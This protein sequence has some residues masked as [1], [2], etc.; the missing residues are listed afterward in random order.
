[1]YIYI[2]IYILTHLVPKIL[3]TPSFFLISPAKIPVI[4]GTVRFGCEGHGVRHPDRRHDEV[5]W[6]TDPGHTTL[7]AAVGCSNQGGQSGGQQ[8]EWKGQGEK[9]ER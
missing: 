1:M 6:E 8:R 7:S 4:S 9:R 3:L 2:Y 5:L